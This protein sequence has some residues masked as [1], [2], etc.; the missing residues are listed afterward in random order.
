MHLKGLAQCLTHTK[1]PV[2]VTFL[3]VTVNP[4]SG[5]M[6]QSSH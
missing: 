3:G 6:W 5:G 4:A 2:S 1:S